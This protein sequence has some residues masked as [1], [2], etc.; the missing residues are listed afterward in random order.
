VQL[1]LSGGN[2]SARQFRL[3]RPSRSEAATQFCPV[4]K[5]G[6]RLTDPGVLN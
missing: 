2:L 4:V 6:L 3:V 1:E 5:R